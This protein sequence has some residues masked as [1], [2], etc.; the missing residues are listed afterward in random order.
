[1]SPPAKVN[2]LVD[3]MAKNANVTVIA[4]SKKVAATEC[5]QSLALHGG[6][7]N[8]YVATLTHD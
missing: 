1:L 2:V 7:F 4:T 3:V 6:K 8:G 5:Q